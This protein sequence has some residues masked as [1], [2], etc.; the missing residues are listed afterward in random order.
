[1]SIGFQYIIVTIILIATII[2]M[3]VSI[4]RRCRNR[5]SACCNCAISDACKNARNTRND[6]RNDKAVPRHPDTH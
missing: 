1:M 3:V 4:R 2:Y 6:T 5:G